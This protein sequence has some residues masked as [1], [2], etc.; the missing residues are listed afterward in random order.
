MTAMWPGSASA[1]FQNPIASVFAMF[2]PFENVAG[3]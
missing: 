3:S 2:R 1:I